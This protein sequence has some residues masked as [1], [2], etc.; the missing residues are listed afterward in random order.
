MKFAFCE[1][2]ASCA[3]LR[4]GVLPPLVVIAY[5][6]VLGQVRGCKSHIICD[7]ILFSVLIA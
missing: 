4:V 7:E 3:K 6:Y 1:Q 5:G 2:S